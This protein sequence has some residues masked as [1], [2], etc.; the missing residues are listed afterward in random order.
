MRNK[1]GVSIIFEK[2]V[3]HNTFEVAIVLITETAD[4]DFEVF[5]VEPFRPIVGFGEGNRECTQK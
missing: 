4:T 5:H 3:F 2:Q 1:Q